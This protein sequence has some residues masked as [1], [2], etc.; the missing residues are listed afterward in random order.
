MARL[1]IPTPGRRIHGWISPAIP[2][3]T[4]RPIPASSRTTRTLAHLRKQYPALR[5]GSFVTLFTGDTL[6]I[7]QKPNTARN[8]YAYAR[9]LEGADSAMVAMNNGSFINLAV[10][11]VNGIFSDGTQLQDALSGTHYVVLGGNVSITLAAR[12]GALLLPSPAKVDL[13]PPIASIT[14]TPSSNG[15]GWYQHQP[16][17]G[18]FQRIRFRQR[19]RTAALLDRQWSGDG[20]RGKQCLDPDQRCGHAVRWDCARAT[21]P[22]T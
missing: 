20:S 13:T 22:A 15:R 18:A 6:A 10:I 11:P 5:N 19:R 12:T 1:A 4:A 3:S 21:A 17:D 16:G 9:V 7:G 8:T 14:T 2:P